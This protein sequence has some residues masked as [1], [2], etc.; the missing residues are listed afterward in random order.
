MPLPAARVG[1][2]TVHGGAI[3]GPGCPTVFIGG[4]PAARI[5]DSQLCPLVDGLKPHVG[6][7]ITK[8]CATVFIGGRMAARVGDL[9][10]CAGPPG[11]IAPPGCLTVLIGL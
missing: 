10:Q 4:K 2:L 7:L 5:L 11:A 6:G 8:G 3:T 9:T 1:D